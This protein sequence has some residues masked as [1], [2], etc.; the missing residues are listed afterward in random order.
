[1]M[2][3]SW[4]E[5]L[6]IVVLYS[7]IGWIAECVYA[8]IHRKK[9][10]NRGL[11]TGPFCPV[12][13]IGMLWIAI[14][15]HGLR[16][17]PLFLFVGSTVV[18]GFVEW[19]SGI[20]IEKIFGRRMWDYSDKFMNFNGYTCLS[21]ASIFGLCAAVSLLFLFPWARIWLGWIPGIV[22]KIVFLVMLGIMLIDMAGTSAV[23]LKR[24]N[25]GKLVPEVT[26]QLGQLSDRINRGIVNL[27]TKRMERAFP[28]MKSYRREK[29]EG[30]FAEGCSFYKLVWL[31]FLGA[32][33]G[34]ITE[35]IFCYITSGKLMSRSSVIYGP[36]SIVWG[37]GCVLLTAF[38]Y[39]SRN[40]NIGYIFIQ[41]TLLGG[42]YE[43]M[44]SVFTE[45]VF[46]TVFW[47]YS[48]IPFNLGGRV[49]LLFC[50]YWG[51]A[52][53]AWLKVLYPFLSKWIEKIPSKIG[54][55]LSWVCIILMIVNILISAA[56]LARYSA[57][58]A[59]AEP[60]NAVECFL[61]ETYPDTFMQIRYPNAKLR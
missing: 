1:M 61:D 34:D 44:C 57:R 50:F 14:F 17:H 33:W 9:F 49:N 48:H 56:A 6:A 54:P 26:E 37:L 13:G 18:A 53:V 40:K 8:A 35:T 46:G 3:E 60:Q 19:L 32:F 42:T 16:S 55:A 41:G 30:V 31:F 5:L 28:A 7:I 27:V 52:A 23:L 15:F 11:L 58:S 22:I 59:G 29:G 47:D 38:L 36:F 10:V 24:K 25:S 43:Y 12:Y 51:I 4:V 2:R 45:A 20:L 21:Y 39:Q